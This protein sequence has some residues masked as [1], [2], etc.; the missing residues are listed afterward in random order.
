MPFNSRWATLSLLAVSFLIQSCGD[1]KEKEK[2]EAP[3]LVMPV[4]NADSAYTFVAEQVAF[5]PRIPNTQAHRETGDYLIRKLRSYGARVTVQE[6]QST[7]FS[8]QKLALRNIVGSFNPAM[9]KR[10]LLGAHWDTRPWSDKDA[11]YPRKTFDGANDGASGVAVL[12][13]VARIMKDKPSVGVDIIF[14]DGEDYAEPEGSPSVPVTGGLDSWWC[15]G[16]QYWSKQKHAPGYRAFYGILLDMVG[17]EKAQFF[18]EG[19]SLVYA[20]R[21]VEKV[22][23]TAQRMG[24]GST[25]VLQRQGPITDD[26]L[27]VSELGGIPM[28]DI[29]HYDPA[30][31]Y[32]ST[33]HHTQQDNLSIISRE[34]LG[35]VGRV[36]VQVVYSEN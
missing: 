3:A 7:A 12:L 34:T 30:V 36:L 4:F 2:P 15:L 8:G 18:Q 23:S 20:P 28:I 1:R 10:I 35:I 26:H 27:F 32:F 16:S 33:Y 5:G 21:I 24:Y 19:S 17:A 13:E 22:W 6:F 29:T 9:Q 31:G 14:F 25:F 11:T